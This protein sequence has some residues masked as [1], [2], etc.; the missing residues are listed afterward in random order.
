MQCTT[1][2]S[3]SYRAHSQPCARPVLGT[4]R[5][6]GV[7]LSTSTP[8]GLLHTLCQAQR[9]SPDTR[10][11]SSIHR[12]MPGGLSL[13]EVL[14]EVLPPVSRHSPTEPSRWQKLAKAVLGGV[15]AGVLA[16]ALVCR[17]SSLT[18]AVQTLPGTDLQLQLDYIC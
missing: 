8:H 7:H 15:G 13:P 1:A 4:S 2:P 17:V 18:W 14:P 12:Q 6:T 9:S 11:A 16:V 5:H 3:C 10:D